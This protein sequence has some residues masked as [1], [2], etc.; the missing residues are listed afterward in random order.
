MST[1][2]T[3]TP[4]PQFETVNVWLRCLDVSDNLGHGCGFKVNW[5]TAP[6]VNHGPPEAETIEQACEL[7][8]QWRDQQ[9]ESRVQALHQIAL[10]HT[11]ETGHYV[12]INRHSRIVVEESLKRFEE[13]LRELRASDSD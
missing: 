11:R 13:E 12:Q 4:V 6:A 2:Q 9:F 3:E 10:I 1:T 7:D 8:A 5:E